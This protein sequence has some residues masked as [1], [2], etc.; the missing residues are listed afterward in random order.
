VVLVGA[1]LVGRSFWRLVRVDPGFSAENVL[2]V[3]VK[4]P[5]ARYAD[6]G[7][8]PAFYGEL[9]ARVRALPG[10]RDAAVASDIPFSGRAGDWV[11]EVEGRPATEASTLPSPTFVIVSA[12]YF[13]AMGVPLRGGRTFGA[14]DGE[15]TA[16]ALVVNR[17][18]ARAF[19]PGGEA[20]GK[21]VRFG[22]GSDNFHFP[23][24]E[25]VG[26]A[27]DVRGQALDAE[28]RPTYYLLDRQFP[29][30]VGGAQRRMMLLVRAAGDPLRLVRPVREAVWSLDREL[31]LADVRTL[32]DVVAGSV[33]RPRFAAL[34]LAAF[35]SAA[36]V[37]AVI[38]VYGVLSYAVTRRRR[39]MGI[40]MALGARAADL[41]RLVVGQGMRVALAGL[42]AGLL[43]ALAGA[44][45]VASLL[46]GV[47]PTDAATFGAAALLLVAAAAVACWVPARRAA[48]LDP[49]AVLR[50]E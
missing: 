41:R 20:V 8:V 40:R 34:V 43:A 32:G 37:L 23:W 42:A 3:D 45:L 50:A 9:L 17:A 10:V 16:P 26:V 15:R 24:M 31:A 14:G 25:V 33:A 4:L 5:E 29:T 36:L 49:S 46:Y 1:G 12:D 2:A 7:R 28:A 19:W 38:G 30:I 47:S 13:R 11:V 6:A 39:E 35:G 27:G 44:R 18:M 48:R 22:S 21:R